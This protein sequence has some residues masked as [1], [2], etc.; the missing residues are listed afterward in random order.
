[1]VGGDDLQPAG[2]TAQCRPGQPRATGPTRPVHPAH[3]A[4]APVRPAGC[5][6]AECLRSGRRRRVRRLPGGGE[7]A[8]AGRLVDRGGRARARD[9]G[10]GRDR[11]PRPQQRRRHHRWPRARPAL[12]GRLPE[13]GREHGS[14]RRARSQRRPGARRTRVVPEARLALVGTADRLPGAVRPRRAAPAGRRRA[15]LPAGQQLGRLDPGGRAAGRRRLLHP[16]A[17]FPDRRPLHPRASS[18]ATTRSAATSRSTRPPG[19]T[20]TTAGW[21]NRS[22]ASTSRVWRPR[23]SC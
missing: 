8:F 12:P 23:A 17:G 5:R 13:G 4:A 18:T 11:G 15:Q 1:M 14:D 20:A 19:S 9:R 21:S 10:G 2:G 16:R 3:V 7:E 6:P 22:S